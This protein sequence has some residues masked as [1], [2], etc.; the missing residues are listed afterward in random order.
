MPALIMPWGSV[1]PGKTCPPFVVPMN[2]ITR[3]AGS[4]ILGIG[5]IEAADVALELEL[6][7]SKR[8][9]HRSFKGRNHLHGTLSIDNAQK[10]NYSQIFHDLGWWFFS[11][12]LVFI[13]DYT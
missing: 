11:L 10:A 2:G 1:A 3:L 12:V 6:L 7:L 9:R 5:R 8:I 13:P 4:V